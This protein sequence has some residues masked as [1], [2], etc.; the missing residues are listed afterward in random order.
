MKGI[1][2]LQLALALLIITSIQGCVQIKKLLPNANQGA[3]EKPLVAD[4]QDTA[5]IE[6]KSWAEDLKEISEKNKNTSNGNYIVS[7]F[8]IKSA[9][10]NPETPVTG[11]PIIRSC[12]ATAL[13]ENDGQTFID[14]N[15]EQSEGDDFVTIMYYPYGGDASSG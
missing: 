14:Y 8:A 2:R 7:L 9:P 4:P 5:T 13:W 6:C 3:S 11:K 1:R 12:T 15:I 10:I